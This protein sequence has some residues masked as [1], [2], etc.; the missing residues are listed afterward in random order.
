MV[1]TAAIADTSGETTA[2]QLLYRYTRTTDID[3]DSGQVR[4]ELR[5]RHEIEGSD[6]YRGLAPALLAPLTAARTSGDAWSRNPPHQRPRQERT[7]HRNDYGPLVVSP[8]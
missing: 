2:H 4:V 1:L 7:P 3:T 6:Y 5:H 8:R